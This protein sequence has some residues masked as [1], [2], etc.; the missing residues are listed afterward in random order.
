MSATTARWVIAG[1][2][3]AAIMGREK[4]EADPLA[5]WCATELIMSVGSA[6][7]PPER[8]SRRD[9]SSISGTKP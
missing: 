8:G 3:A 4:A 5:W 1:E 6:R 2:A 7:L 9:Q